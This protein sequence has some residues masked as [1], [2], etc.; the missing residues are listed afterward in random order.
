MENSGLRD[1]FTISSQGPQLKNCEIDT[2]K[3]MWAKC[4]S[5]SSVVDPHWFLDLESAFL[6]NADPDPVPH[7]EIRWPKNADPDPQNWA[8]GNANVLSNIRATMS[9]YAKYT[10][11]NVCHISLTK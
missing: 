4:K 11:A 1:I 3:Y 8:K 2:C 6:V 7:P 5:N 9:I 10:Y